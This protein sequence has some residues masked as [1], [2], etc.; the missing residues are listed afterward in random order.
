MWV[1]KR[2]NKIIGLTVSGK[3]AISSALM[4]SYDSMNESCQCFLVVDSH[5]LVLGALIEHTLAVLRLRRCWLPFLQY[6]TLSVTD[7]LCTFL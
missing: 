5:K 3:A 2:I 7:F 6:G 4:D 1:T